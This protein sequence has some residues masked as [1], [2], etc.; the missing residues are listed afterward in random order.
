MNTVRRAYLYLACAV[1]V[2]AVA[3]AAIGLLRAPTS[4]EPERGEAIAFSASLAIV[5]LPLLLLH[6]RWV[7]HSVAADPTERSSAIR[8]VYLYCSI[9]LFLLPL[10]ASAYDLLAAAL[11]AAIGLDAQSVLVAPFS[12]PD[13]A[14]VPG[15]MQ[16]AWR[17]LSAVLV[18]A[19]AIA[20]HASALR[21]D[22]ASAAL[23]P[24][25]AGVRRAIVLGF[26]LIGA[27]LTF[28]AATQLLRW[29]ML[30]SDPGVL[31]AVAA[32]RSAVQEAARATIGLATWI[33]FWLAAQRLFY[34][35]NEA[36]TAEQTLAERRSAL[37]KVYL[38]GTVFVTELAVIAPAAAIIGGALRSR[39]GLPPSGHLS[40][41]LPYVPVAVVAWLYHARVLRDDA[42]VGIE[43]PRQAAV[44]RTHVYLLSA[45]GLF[46]VLVGLTGAVQ[47][48]LD[49]LAGLAGVAGAPADASGLALSAPAREQVAWSAAIVIAGLP[50]WLIAW[51]RAQSAA[52]SSDGLSAQEE[53]QSIV[54]RL[55]LYFFLFLTTVAVLAGAVVLIYRAL[56]AVLGVPTDQQTLQQTTAAAAYCLVGAVAW[57]YHL[58]V[59]RGDLAVEAGALAERLRQ[60][61]VVLALGDDALDWTASEARE[62]ETAVRHR[63]E[64]ELPAL[65]LMTS[66]EPSVLSSAD[67]VIAGP[68]YLSGRADVTGPADV[69]GPAAVA[70][71]GPALVL[72][73]PAPRAGVAW[74]G[75][76][77]GDHEATA[78]HVAHALR[79]IAQG[80]PVE[81]HR[82]PGAGTMLAVAAGALVLLLTVGMPVLGFVLGGGMSNLFRP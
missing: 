25:A 24:Q 9:A 12:E 4:I 38:H 5:A 41:P 64:A 69:N 47:S 77:P 58:R 82:P 35:S 51:H 31:T 56:S 27:A 78:A 63:V 26:S 11:G 28:V 21:T 8:A 49:A 81:P 10:L 74:V 16:L 59:L 3:W 76:E 65:T 22:R 44:R 79:L 40:G 71:P 43:T 57:L 45:V 20:L 66:R 17:S 30:H 53:R 6:W 48:L 61:R 39:L 52:A 15:A 67:V 55:Y 60:L 68:A 1:G 18:L 13:A 54:R 19:G 46:A 33:P 14:D 75:L 32:P 50:T 23:T 2:Q 36:A 62:L 29:L 42:A 73:V 80:K 37:R 72:A 34:G 7:R 70:G